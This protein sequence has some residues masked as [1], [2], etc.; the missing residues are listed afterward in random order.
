MQT[1][2]EAVVFAGFADTRRPHVVETRQG[3][4]G[5]VELNV[6]IADPVRS[7]PFD[8]VLELEPTPHINSDPV[9]QRHFIAPGKKPDPITLAE[10][11]QAAP[12]PAERTAVR[13]RNLDRPW[14]VLCDRTK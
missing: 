8:C 6:D 11:G 12:L 13:E 7:R 3:V 9:S 1:E 10:R 4:C 5:G 14:G 2:V